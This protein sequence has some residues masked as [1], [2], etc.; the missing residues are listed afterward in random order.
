MISASCAGATHAAKSALG[1]SLRFAGVSITVGSTA[2]TLMSWERTSSAIERTSWLRPALDAAYA[3]IPA[4]GGW[5]VARELTKTM[6]PN[7]RFFIPG[8][9]ARASKSAD[10]RLVLRRKSMSASPAWACWHRSP[11][12]PSSAHPAR[13]LTEPT[14]W[15]PAARNLSHTAD[16][17]T[18]SAPVTK[19][20]LTL[21]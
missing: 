3:P 20:V 21:I 11:G 5:I 13:A 9:I 17:R 6:R 14:T 7:P 12:S 4:P 2:F 8:M 16:P 15:I 10:F 18:P 1:I 19:T